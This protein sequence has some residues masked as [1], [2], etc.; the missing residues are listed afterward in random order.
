MTK[1]PDDQLWTR[2]SV[3]ETQEI[4]RTWAENYDQDVKDWGYATPPRVA[5][6][7]R[8]SGANVEKGVLDYGCG[9][10]LAGMALGSGRV[11]GD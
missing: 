8:L 4:Y 5:L 10:G 6:A 1:S 11:P 7:L 2:H 3:E 9:T